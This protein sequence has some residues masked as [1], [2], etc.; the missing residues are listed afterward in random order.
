MAEE[1]RKKVTTKQVVF[2]RNG[3]PYHGKIEAFCDAV[4]NGGINF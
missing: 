2:D 3:Y 1:L 4:R